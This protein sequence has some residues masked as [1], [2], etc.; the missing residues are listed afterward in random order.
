M[1]SCTEMLAQVSVPHK[2]AVLGW[3]TWLSWP[4]ERDP[5]LTH[6]SEKRTRHVVFTKC[7]T[8]KALFLAGIHRNGRT[9]VAMEG[10]Q[11]WCSSCRNCSINY[12]LPGRTFAPCLN[13][14]NFICSWQAFSFI[15][16]PFRSASKLASSLASTFTSITVP[17][18]LGR[19]LL[20][21]AQPHLPS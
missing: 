7:H 14:K 13:D 6:G 9:V 12:A 3:W 19:I 2:T 15:L 8:H 11:G 4:P 1:P 10:G 17:G 20:S 16:H 5:A 18:P 21:Q